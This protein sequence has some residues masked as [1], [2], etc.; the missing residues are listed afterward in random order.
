MPL[1]A[2]SALV[3]QQ[4]AS[5]S[6]QSPL[7]PQEQQQLHLP[8]IAISTNGAANERGT[9]TAPTKS[10]AVLEPHRRIKVSLFLVFVDAKKF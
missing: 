4:R 10:A 6:Q 2:P 7:R 9:S 3:K 5:V 1:D 8:S